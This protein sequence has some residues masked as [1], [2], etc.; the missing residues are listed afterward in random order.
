MSEKRD[1]IRHIAFT[2]SESSKIS[3][4]AK[5]YGM[6]S[7]EFIRQAINDKIRSIEYPEVAKNGN[8]PEISNQLIKSQELILEEMKLMN[9]KMTTINGIRNG[10]KFLTEIISDTTYK[11]NLT[12]KADKIK[13][14]MKANDKAFTPKELNTITGFDLKSI[15]LALT[16]NQDL[17]KLN[18][19]GRW[20]L[21][22]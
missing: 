6:T 3:E 7:S 22:E 18:M 16:S 5:D 21:N 9:A 1:K 2:E 12:L 4:Y 14:V 15:D 19:N 11:E 8:N 13:E 20:E 17:F 10:Y